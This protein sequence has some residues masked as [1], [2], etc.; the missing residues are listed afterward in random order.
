MRAE[1]PSRAS[2]L[3]QASRICPVI[4][5][6]SQATLTWSSKEGNDPGQFP[7]RCGPRPRP[8]VNPVRGVDVGCLARPACRADRLIRDPQEVPPAVSGHK[9]R[10]LRARVRLFACVKSPDRGWPYRQ[11]VPGRAVPEPL[12]QLGDMR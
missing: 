2:S 1:S 10:Q 9:Q 4:S 11:L 7:C 6:V 3:S 8:G 5:A 12:G